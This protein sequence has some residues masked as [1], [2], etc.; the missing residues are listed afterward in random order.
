MDVDGELPQLRA[1]ASYYASLNGALWV[2]EQDGAIVGMIAAIPLPD[3]AWEICQVY[4]HPS[5]HGTGLG[6]EL[7]DI[8]ERHAASAA[9][10]VLWTDT[11]FERAHRFYEKRSY[12][13]TA[14]IRALN[15][16]SSSLEFHYEKPLTGI[17]VLDIASAESA[18][19]R[20]SDILIACVAEGAGV[21]FLPPL[22]PEVAKSFWRTTA[23][24]IAAG[25]KILLAGWVDGVLAG[26]VTLSVD[27]PENQPHRAEVAKLLVDPAAR[28]TGLA[29]RLM[30]RLEAE[31][32][33][34]GRPLLML[35]TRAGD[36][37]EALYRSMGWH[38]LGLVPGHALSKD[39]SFD[40]TRFFW[41]RVD[42]A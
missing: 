26:T 28:R 40:D 18:V 32:G 1:L 22:A 35:D 31:A 42:A 41:K 38:E 23:R 21:S 13:R 14:P 10:F 29:R 20:L 16:I 9:R 19:P 11:R 36:R 6:H 2:A 7:L 37:A 34:A 33:K 3:D 5:L 27:M 17:E 24:D 39:G 25:R 12:I 30:A 15:D 4:V 8:A